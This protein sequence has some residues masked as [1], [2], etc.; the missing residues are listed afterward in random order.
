[1]KSTTSHLRRCIGSSQAPGPASL[2]AANGTLS[3]RGG[4]A[5]CIPERAENERGPAGG[6]HVLHRPEEARSNAA[7]QAVEF[8]VEIGEYRDVVSV[9]RRVFQRLYLSDNLL[10]GRDGY[11]AASTE[12]NT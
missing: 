5:R 3:Q 10:P 2:S 1:M 7:R 6:R 8:G 11:C 9:R 4:M 12:G